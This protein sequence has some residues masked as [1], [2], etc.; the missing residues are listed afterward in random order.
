MRVKDDRRCTNFG[1]INIS[2]EPFMIYLMEML[3]HI[4]CEC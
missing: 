1:T 4:N 2:T 3:N